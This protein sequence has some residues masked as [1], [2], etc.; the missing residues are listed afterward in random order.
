MGR[1]PASPALACDAS[2]PSRVSPYVAVAVR[3]FRRFA[4]YRGATLAGVF[5]N[6]VFG[7]I[8]AAVFAAAHER[9]GDVGGVTVEQTVLFVFSAQAFLAMTGAFGDREI[10]ERIRTGDVAADLYRPVDFQLWWLSHD[11][12]KAAFQMIFRGIP[13]FVIGVWVLSL[14]LPRSALAWFGFSVAMVLG[15]VL[16]FGIRFLANLSAFWL[17]EARGIVNLTAITQA[18]LAG[19][20]VPLYFMPD[21]LE[22]LVRVLPFAG[23]TA[24]PI[25]ILIGVRTGAEVAGVFVHQVL[26]ILILGALGRRILGMAYRNVV[27]QGG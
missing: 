1:M 18:F 3:A 22:S 25:E 4:T 5:T 8:Y 17:L 15:V 23:I 26:W 27:V 16:A 9:V 13:P 19:H 12:G 10:S 11:L 24:H 21:G 14:S 7:F 2:A 20:F 6:T